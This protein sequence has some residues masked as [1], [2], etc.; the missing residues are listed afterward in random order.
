MSTRFSERP[1]NTPEQVRE[2]LTG[3]LAIVA[4]LELTDDLRVPAFQKAADLLASKQVVAER[5]EAV[6]I[7]L[8]VRRGL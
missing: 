5:I 3:A 1:N 4:E 2:Y 8:A 6:P 7:D